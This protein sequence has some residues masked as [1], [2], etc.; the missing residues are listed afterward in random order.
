[1]TLTNVFRRLMLAGLLLLVSSDVGRADEKSVL[2]V[3][4]RGND[5]WSGRLPAPDDT[6]QDGPLATLIG[7]RDAIRRMR[8]E[9]RLTGAVDVMLLDG[10][11]RLA[12]PLVLT[13]ED[14]GGAESPVTWTAFPGHHPVLSGARTVD[15]WKPYQGKIQQ[16]QIPQAAEGKWTFRQIFHRGQRQPRARWP[17]PDPADPHY[18]GWAFIESEAA[19]DP[20]PNS[21]QFSSTQPPRLWAHPGQAEL[22]VFPWYCWV[23]DIIPVRSADTGRQTVSLTRGPRFSMPLMPGNRFRVENMLEELDQP[24][25]WCLRTDT[26]T[27]YF[28][29]P[30]ELRPGDVAAPV[31]DTL[32]ELRGTADAPV[33]GVTIRGLSLTE[34]RTPFPDDAHE[35]FHSPT[36]RGAAISLEHCDGCRIEGNR[37]LMLGGDGV[38]LQGPNAHNEVIANEIGHTGGAGVVLVSLDK[39]GNAG[40]TPDFENQE[41]LRRHSSRYPKLIR[42]VVSDNT[43]HHCGY[44]KKNCGGVHLYAIN[45]IDNRFDHNQI[46]DMSDKGMVMQDGFGRYVVEYNDMHDLGLEIADTGGIMVNRWFVLDDD[47]ELSRGA[48]IRFNR[49][50]NCVGCGAYAETRHPKGE[51]DGTTA[52]G[53]IWTPYYTWGIYFDNSGRKNTVFGNIVIGTVLGGVSLPV[54]NPRDNLVENN[55]LVGSSG[56]QLD[57]RLSGAN[58][59]FRRNILYYTDPRAML[60]AAS[61]TTGQAVAECDENLYFLATGGEPKVRGAGSLSDW[62]KLGFDRNS[63]VADPRFVDSAK[64]DYRLQPES[65]AWRLGFQPIPMEQFGPRMPVQAANREPTPAEPV[66][67]LSDVGSAQAEWFPSVPVTVLAGETDA[68]EPLAI[69]TNTG[70]LLVAAESRAKGSVLLARSD[71]GGA[72]WQAAVEIART[73]DGRPLGGANRV[74]AGSGGTLASGRLVLALHEWNEQPGNVTWIEEKPVG[75]HHYSWSG[76]RRRSTLRVLKS[77]DQGRTWNPATCSLE[78]GPIAPAAMGKVFVSDNVAWMPVFGPADEQEMDAALSGAGLMRSDDG[79][80]SWR[81]SHW[82]ARANVKQQIAYGP[83]EITVLPNG[84]WLGMLQANHRRPGDYA[85]PRI[86]RTVSSDGGRTWS[87]PTATLLGPRPTL[88]QLDR[89]QLMV[90]TRQDRGIIFNILLNAGTD[91]LYQDQLWETIW[92]EG[93]ERGGLNLLKLD[94]DSLIATHHWMDP[95]HL[96]RCEIR[97][98]LVKRRPEF[99]TPLPETSPQ[100]PR[101][102]EWVMAE[103]FQVPDIA[104][105]PGGTKAQTLLKL[106]SGDWIAIGMATVIEGTGAHGFSNKDFVT[107]RAPALNGP[108]KKVGELT[109]LADVVGDATGSN[110]PR[111]MMQTRSGRLL[112]PVTHGAWNSADRDMNLLYSD[113]DGATWGSV[114]LLGKQLGMRLLS[115]AQRIEQL[116][117]GQLLWILQVGRDDWQPAKGNLLCVTSTDDGVSWQP[118]TWFGRAHDKH[119]AGLPSGRNSFIRT[120]EGQ[121]LKTTAGHWLGMYREERGSLVPGGRQ[122]DPVGMANLM[123]TRSEDGRHW[124]PAFGFLGVEPD[125]AVL[126]G[127]AI[128][129]AY[130][131]DNLA[132]A[133]LS[134]DHGRTWQWQTDFCEVPWRRA[135]IEA[136]GQWPPGGEAA[137]RV[138]DDTTAVTIC[139]SGLLPTGKRLPKGFEGTKELH[140]RLQ[141]RFFRRV[142]VADPNAN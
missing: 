114:G 11:Y 28:W 79:G 121:L 19:N 23:N 96:S 99:R 103:A 56:N 1:M 14:S 13:A 46:H 135:A 70:A 75:T 108:W 120:P 52:D 134:Y 82:M 15:G 64:G 111:P 141:V 116:A 37:L 9:N 132:T 67:E 115:S 140:G 142:R 137:V 102:E 27:L 124:T 128:L 89:G 61:G 110:M 138:L 30:D 68:I 39:E 53:R 49:I 24:G 97:S 66:N 86:S 48:I 34:T 133:W 136:H 20:H 2:Y 29:P 51:G 77:D 69:R 7:A 26:G 113:N 32:I 112:L 74:S 83:G 119:Y 40:D 104:A 16:T 50:R 87:A 129:A 5:R 91:L 94:D 65:P 4:P 76:F 63:V 38:R 100:A 22:N 55:I 35:N 60:L 88:A 58:N 44:F 98:Q 43:I 78:G 139:E 21:H 10:T 8:K 36:K 62:R 3:S 125:M 126:P 131:E 117:D 31:I 81:F 41:T 106:K 90:G 92:Y 123:L 57:L 25:E 47:P 127:G 59:R 85:R 101:D 72:S 73:A 42:N 107:V 84:T 45:S 17:N 54:G 95:T 105:A 33:R 130:R 80:A 18:S 93:G 6:Q 118:L 71:D 109:P 122:G 12:E